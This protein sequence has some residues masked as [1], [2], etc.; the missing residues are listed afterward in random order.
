M[1]VHSAVL[2]VLAQLP[3][4]LRAEIL[5]DMH[6]QGILHFSSLFGKLGNECAMQIL[7]K[8]QNDVRR[9]LNPPHTRTPTSPHARAP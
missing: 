3:T 4:Q 8:L 5:K 6:G 7:A 1:R 9:I 2:Q